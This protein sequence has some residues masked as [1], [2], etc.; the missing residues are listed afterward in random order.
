MSYEC[1]LC[2]K[3]FRSNYILQKHINQKIKCTEKNI[4][5][6][7]KNKIICDT[8][9]KTFKNNYLYTKHINSYNSCNLP[10]QIINKKD[11]KDINTEII[12]DTNNTLDLPKLKKKLY[13]LEYKYTT[14]NN[15]THSSL[16]NSCAF[17]N[18]IFTRKQSLNRHLKDNNCKPMKTLL[19][20]IQIL[21]LDIEK[22]IKFKDKIINTMEHK[23]KIKQ[24]NKIK[25]P[26]ITT[27]NNNTNNTTNNITNN[28]TNTINIQMNNYGKEDLSHISDKD[29]RQFINTMFKGFIMMIE[30]IH[31]NENKPENFNIYLSN[32]KNN[33]AHIYMN[34]TWKVEKIDD[35][36]DKI[37][38][39]KINILNQKVNELNDDNLKDTLETF[40][41]RLYY[42]PN[43][44]KN[45]NDD[46]KY[47]MY[48][49]RNKV[50]KYKKQIK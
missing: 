9:K 30:K 38:D 33:F 3:C 40:K 17:C 10:I 1:Q 15:K 50:L 43:A 35:V 20:E 41:E 14:I 24:I 4:I 16:N 7:I 18:H 26:I 37:K 5:C 2:K 11:K 25:N 31:F 8:C 46:I 23:N 32:L 12:E 27:N 21:K 45:T 39:D 13:N 47:S 49:N 6:K 34:D 29:Y 48:N 22:Y 42:H 36:I 19:N 44:E 28:I